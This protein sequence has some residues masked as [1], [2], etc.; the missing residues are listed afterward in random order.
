MYHIHESD[1]TWFRHTIIRS[2]Q[3]TYSIFLSRPMDNFLQAS[4][5][6]D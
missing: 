1:L 4:I 3:L 2:I 5:S 6:A